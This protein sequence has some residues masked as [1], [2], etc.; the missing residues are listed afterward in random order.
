M[1]LFND[2]ERATTIRVKAHVNEARPEPTD[3]Q[4]E[5]TKL[6][7][8]VA[9]NKKLLTQVLA[10]QRERERERE[11]EIERE[12]ETSTSERSL[13]IAAG[14]RVYL[15]KHGVLERDMIQDV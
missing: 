10:Q 8:K 12:R 11:R 4:R 15:C 3:T 2:M 9:E 6:W 5:F 14:E 13:M 7:S 1:K